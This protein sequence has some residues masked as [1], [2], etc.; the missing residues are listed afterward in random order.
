MH[1]SLITRRSIRY[2][3]HYKHYRHYRY[4]ELFSLSNI[5]QCFQ[6]NKTAL[7]VKYI[8]FLSDQVKFIKWICIGNDW[9]CG[10]GSKSVISLDLDSYKKSYFSSTQEVICG[11]NISCLGELHA[12]FAH[13]RAIGNLINSSGIED[14][15]LEAAWYD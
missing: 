1:G 7:L 5:E 14:A 15:W 6:Y 11:I 9:T 10:A 8:S 2:H 13:I 3:T 4:I 12:V